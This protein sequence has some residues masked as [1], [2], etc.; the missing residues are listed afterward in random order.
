MMKVEEIGRRERGGEK[1][2][3]FNGGPCASFCKLWIN[4]DC[5]IAIIAKRLPPVP[6]AR[7]VI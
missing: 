4:G 3:P 2:C 1:I 5:A 6:P 7:G